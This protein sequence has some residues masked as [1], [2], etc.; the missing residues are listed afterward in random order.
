V[1]LSALDLIWAEGTIGKT[2]ALG[3]IYSMAKTKVLSAITLLV[4]ASLGL[5]A[6]GPKP[7]PRL[8]GSTIRPAEI[9][10]TVTRLM[11]NAEVPGVGIA[12]LNHGKIAYLKAYGFRDR[13]Q[14]LPLTADSVMT[15]A[16][17][18]K[19]VFAYLAMKLVDEGRLDLDKPVEQYFPKPLPEYPAYSDLAGDPRYKRIT[20]RMLLSHTAGFPNL[21]A[22]N[23]DRKLNINFDPGS[24]FAYSGEGIQLLQLVIETITGRPLQELM[25]EQ[26]FQP[27]N[28]TRTSM[29]TE[30]R[31]EN[32]YANAYDEW[33]RSLGHQNRKRAD[34]AGSMQTT[35]RDVTEFALAMMQGRGL[36]KSTREL[37]LSPQIRIVSKHEFPTLAPE[38]TDENKAIELSYGLGLGLYMSPYGRAF[39]KE[40]HDDGFRHYMVGFDKPRD[41]IVVMTNSSNGEGIY[42][43]ILETLLRDTFTPI[44]WEGFAPYNEP[45]HT[46]IS[47]DPGVLERLGGNY[48]SRSGIALTVVPKNGHLDMLAAGNGHDLF[49]E[50]ELRF[51]SKTL[52]VIAD[53]ELDSQGRATRLTL[54]YTDGD[55]VMSRTD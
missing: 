49:P 35:L 52:H 53:F 42:K 48:A 17:F 3:R 15:G 43:E 6:A 14:G 26:V 28:M 30:E 32:D 38:T 36:R 22:M 7:I 13:E 18:T 41:G 19:A 21:R 10:S 24:R 37:M 44:E 12:I 47:V 45:A 4:L 34:A 5:R 50:G 55:V 54:H 2:V 1:H 31:F 16:S 33:G 29:V 46:A 40:G 20:A 9:D 39:F 8:D 23:R 11:R 51:F 27:L 25:H